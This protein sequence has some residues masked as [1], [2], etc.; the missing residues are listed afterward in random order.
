MF[1]DLRNHIVSKAGTWSDPA[2]LADQQP[3]FTLADTLGPSKLMLRWPNDTVMLAGPLRVRV[4]F[5]SENVTYPVSFNPNSSHWVA[6]DAPKTTLAP[7]ALGLHASTVYSYVLEIPAAQAWPFRFR[8]GELMHRLGTNFGYRVV[9]EPAFEAPLHVGVRGGDLPCDFAVASE[10]DTGRFFPAAC[11]PCPP[12]ASIGLP[13]GGPSLGIPA[14]EGGCI[15]PRWFNG[16]FITREDLETEQRYFRLKG[17]LQN[18]AMGQGVVWGLA[19]GKAG[20]QICVMPGYGV[21]CCGNDLTLSSV[22]RVDIAT[23][24]RDPAAMAAYSQPIPKL[25]PAQQ[26]P[27]PPPPATG[28]A[29]AGRPSRGTTAALAIDRAC[30]GPAAF[31][32]RRGI[33]MHLLLEYIE[34]PSEPRPVHS[35]PC[36]GT[37]NRCEMSRIRETVR[38]RLVPPRDLSLDGPIKKFLDRV[39]ALRV[40]HPLVETVPPL[41]VPA[42]APYQ[43]QVTLL[44]TGGNE[45]VKTFPIDQVP[46]TIETPLP[47]GAIRVGLVLD[48]TWVFTDG[49]LDATD[50]LGN[51]LPPAP[52][53]LATESS[54]V[55]LAIAPNNTKLSVK[56]TGWATENYLAD[57]GGRIVTGTATLDVGLL[58]P[59][60]VGL[61]AGAANGD[62]TTGT[63]ELPE[64][65]GEPCQPAGAPAVLPHLPWMH[66]DPVH[67]DK[68]GDPKVLVLAALGGWLTKL[69]A[70]QKT[71]TD[72]VFTAKRTLATKLYEAAWLVFYGQEQGLSP[73]DTQ[74]ALCH[75]FRDW[76]E[77]FLY[78]GPTCNG[79]PHGVVIGCTVVTGGTIGEI[80]PF[81]GRRWVMHGPLVAHWMG[82]L[83]MAPIDVTASRFMSQL[84]CVASLPSIGPQDKL[85]PMVMKVGEGFVTFGAPDAV[86][87]KLAQEHGIT[88]THAQT[89]TFPELVARFL[90]MLDDVPASETATRYSLGSP[91]EDRV[92]SV[93]IPT[94]KSGKS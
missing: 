38:L 89:A 3:P 44:M 24:L 72:D 88:I 81:G 57:A 47:I 18:R 22:Y 65:C 49:T 54:P 1:V 61:A 86:K 82:Q 14:A 60:Q 48:P 80:D 34:C 46:Q 84:C 45:V 29:I 15:R 92:L 87:A 30:F 19:V 51:P 20:N 67:P 78:K 28:G 56:L 43:F 12:G 41:P 40:A 2:L 94:D 79:E 21:D 32:P 13:P 59:N 17:K 62:V 50:A 52:Y 31:D 68:A 7:G 91:M 23:L 77:A 90:E 10:P 36:A 16:M 71:G 37:A 93:V 25:P 53:A 26:P 9:V 66:G 35:D 85:P 73:A 4:S 63:L 74:D 6:G 33:R 11:E 5:Q 76:C 27:P 70:G 8:D 75:L 55:T 39:A 69:L 64:I 83:G 42:Q 58:K